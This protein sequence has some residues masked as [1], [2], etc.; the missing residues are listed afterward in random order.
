MKSK[1]HLSILLLTLALSASQA[2]AQTDAETACSVATLKGTFGLHGSGTRPV[3]PSGSSETHSTLAL[4][5]YDGKG[6][7]KSWS[8]VSQGSA[9]G[10]SEGD[11]TPMIGTYEVNADCTG[12][13]TLTLRTPAGLVPLVAKFVIVNR[14]LEI[15]EVPVTP[16]N[17]ALA[18]LQRQ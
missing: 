13:V 7:V 1:K 14:G 17:V 9:N 6:G 3:Q 2:Y 10:V 4:R 5:S 15:L 11:G 12:K 16:G 18:R 8:L